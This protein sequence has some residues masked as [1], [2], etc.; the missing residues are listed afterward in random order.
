MY[1]Y[2]DLKNESCIKL[3]VFFEFYFYYVQ[4][5][6]EEKQKTDIRT[7]EEECKL[8]ITFLLHLFLVTIDPKIYL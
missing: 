2:A 4:K 8:Q 5:K 3:Y 6:I 7:I 1:L